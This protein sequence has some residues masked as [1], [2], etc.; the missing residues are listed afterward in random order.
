MYCPIIP[1][2]TFS[3]AFYDLRMSD[4]EL[5]DYIE[6]HNDVL[7]QFRLHTELTLTEK[8]WMQLYM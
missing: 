1:T 7:H 4:E 5:I 6:I 8:Y 3:P 2:P